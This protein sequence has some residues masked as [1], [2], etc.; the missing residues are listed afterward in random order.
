MAGV[1]VGGDGSV[2]I[3]RAL[4]TANQITRETWGL[5]GGALFEGGSLFATYV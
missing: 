1:A 4:A 5:A 2:T 3:T